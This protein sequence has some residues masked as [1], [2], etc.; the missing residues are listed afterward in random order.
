MS[1]R[2]LQIPEPILPEHALIRDAAP[3]PE[4]SAG[5]KQKVIADCKVEIARTARVRRWKV[6][7]SVA[8][9]CCCVLVMSVVLPTGDNTQNG[10]ASH[11]PQ[12]VEAGYPTDSLGYPTQS[13]PIVVDKVKPPRK[14]DAKPQ[15]HQLM[16][17]LEQRQQIFDA[18]MLPKF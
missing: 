9:V 11:E 10:S 3:V 2:R 1:N 17:K 18:N 12:P 5:F 15:M 8:A 6:A 7:G 14:R 16:E 4:L 13:S